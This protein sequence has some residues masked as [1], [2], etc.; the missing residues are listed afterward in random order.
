MNN[1][2]RWVRQHPILVFLAWFFPVGWAIAFI[3][4]IA[5]A[6]AGTDLPI[7]P[8]IILST[9]FGLLL[10]VVVIVRLVDGAAGLQRL[11]QQI[12]R[13]RANPGWYALG[14]V[15]VPALTLALAIATFGLP[16]V[17]P[18]TWL[19]A[20][21]V[22]FLLQT[23]VGFATTNLWEEVAWIGFVQARLQTRYGV[24]LAVLI[25]A[26]L[27]AL[28][29]VPLFVGQSMGF[30]IPVAFFVLTI[31][32]RALMA[33]IY[34]RTDSL[35]VVGL[36]H[37]AGAGAI[38]GTITGVGLLPRGSLLPQWLGGPSA[39]ANSTRA[40]LILLGFV[41][42]VN[43]FISYVGAGLQDDPRAVLFS[44]PAI[45]TFAVLGVL[46]IV[47]SHRTGFPAAWDARVS[48]VQRLLIPALLGIAIGVVQSA[49]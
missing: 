19:N 4:Q 8:F 3:P 41:G 22:G 48:N 43:L 47:L 2:L 40:W 49:L 9:W 20:I 26:V 1:L 14:L 12:T 38:A 13:V 33:W 35:F 36:V 27:F 23:V 44:W 11:R 31:P 42:L 29:H 30:V 17:T 34:N 28:Q 5:M 45:A 24:L 15:L 10:P 46:G 32:F 7:E 6:T 25:T 16:N 37:A 39:T 21:V 18:A